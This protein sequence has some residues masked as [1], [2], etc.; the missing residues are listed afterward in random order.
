MHSAKDAGM[1]PDAGVRPGETPPPCARCSRRRCWRRGESACAACAPGSCAAPDALAGRGGRR[2]RGGRELL[3]TRLGVGLWRRRTEGAGRGLLRAASSRTAPPRSA[4]G[5]S[6][7]VRRRGREGSEEPSLVARAMES[8]ARGATRR[9]RFGRR[10][11]GQVRR[12]R[13]VGRSGRGGGVARRR[14]STSPRGAAASR[15]RTRR[16]TTAETAAAGAPAQAGHR[17]SRQRAMG[18]TAATLKYA[19]SV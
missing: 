15:R 5:P 13:G 14:T 10:V 12:L 18:P 4:G 2:S 16:A 11:R 8:P 7:L 6:A 3:P 19:C 9:L 17:G 1:K